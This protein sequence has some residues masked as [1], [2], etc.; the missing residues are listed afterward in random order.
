[1]PGLDDAV[2]PVGLERELVGPARGRCAPTGRRAAGC[3]ARP[4]G[5]PIG[6]R[7]GWPHSRSDRER[8]GVA[9]S[10]S[11]ISSRPNSKNWASVAYWNG[12]SRPSI[13]AIGWSVA[14]WWACQFQPACGR[15]SPRRMG[16]GSRPTTV[17]TPSPSTTKRKACWVCRC[18]GASSPGMRYWMAAHRVGL[19]KGR[20]PSAGLASAIARRSPPR[21]TGTSSPARSASGRRSAQRHRCGCGL[22]LRVRRHEVADLGPQRDEQLLLEAAVELLELRRGRR[23]GPAPRRRGGARARGSASPANRPVLSALRKRRF[24]LAEPSR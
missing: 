12:M 8:S 2:V 9:R 16:T 7:P 6:V 17:Q 23:A 22:R 1:M 5:T 3:R 11:V 10:S 20:P 4:A 24:C 13:H 21:P 19:T 18:S 15:K 14:L